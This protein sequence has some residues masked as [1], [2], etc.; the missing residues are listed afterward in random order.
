MTTSKLRL[1]RKRLEPGKAACRGY[2]RSGLLQVAAALVALLLV[3]EPA[4]AGGA[5]GVW[6]DLEQED[7]P[8][9]EAMEEFLHALGHATVRVGG[10]DGISLSHASQTVASIVFASQRNTFPPETPVLDALAEF[11]E[12]GGAILQVDYMRHRMHLGYE[13]VDSDLDDGS[14][15]LPTRVY[16]RTVADGTAWADLPR[17]I[18]VDRKAEA[19]YVKTLPEDVLSIYESGTWSFFWV[20][21]VGAGRYAKLGHVGQLF[22][23]GATITDW[24]QVVA[25]T[26]DAFRCGP[27]ASPDTDGDGIPDPC[28]TCPQL[29]DPDQVDSDGDGRG[30]ACDV[31]P[32]SHNPEPRD[33]DGDGLEDACDPDDD[34]DG[35]ADGSDNC[36]WIAN[37]AQSDDD[38]DGL[39]AACDLCPGIPDGSGDR[40]IVTWRDNALASFDSIRS[41]I[42]SRFDFVGGESG[43]S[44]IDGGMGMFGAGNE[45]RRYYRISGTST[46]PLSY[47]GDAVVTNTNLLGYGGRYFTIKRDGLFAFSAIVNPGQVAG[48]YITGTTGASASASIEASIVPLVVKG[49]PYSAYFKKVTEPGRPSIHRILM[50]DGDA[51]GIS[52]LGFGAGDPGKEAHAIRRRGPVGP[53]EFHFLLFSTVDGSAVPDEIMTAMAMAYLNAVVDPAPEDFDGDGQGNLCDD[54]SDGDGV[55]DGADLC[56]ADADTDQ[57]DMDADGY[58]D[59]CDVDADN[60]AIDDQTDNCPFVP[61]STQANADSDSFGNVCDPCP[62]DRRNDA[63]ADGYCADVD[64]CPTFANADQADI[65]GDGRGDECQLC[66][67]TPAPEA[68]ERSVLRL[69][70]LGGT[71]DNDKLTFRADFTLPF[72]RTFAELDPTATPW[73]LVLHDRDE[74]ADYD[75]IDATLPAA[76]YAGEGSAGWL[77]S[78]RGN[79]WIFRDDTAAPSPHDLTSVRLVPASRSDPSRIRLT[80]SA[81]ARNF[82]EYIAGPLE[83]TAAV[84][85][86]MGDRLAGDCAQAT[87]PNCR[88]GRGLKSLGC[89]GD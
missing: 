69:R 3:P 64:N 87:Y 7:I 24:G 32:A 81:S 60:D 11:L 56:P 22:E 8:S 28:D 79:Q 38:A 26:V 37:P 54:D 67:T 17:G 48:I 49:R 80:A 41:L 33:N 40:D 31:C 45:I 47:S 73:R 9:L 82:P 50:A 10:S 77:R 2:V 23:N 20:A 83:H 58:G 52:F 13:L 5:V 70:F 43:R 39:G 15:E 34:N 19:T 4:L 55:P 75:R 78:A 88:V 18:D 89:R 68:L 51:H 74:D 27:A 84:T 62:A 57:S 65:D 53:D 71:P 46:A 85:L 12:N 72:G 76:M 25:R 16:R 44:I 35:V 29:P 30:D 66:P 63:D 1:H 86:I 14:L 6:A 61:N 21:D 42:P 59:A 36:P